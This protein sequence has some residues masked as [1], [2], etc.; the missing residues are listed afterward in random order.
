M[1][2][3]LYDL[4]SPSY[5]EKIL[6]LERIIGYKVEDYIR[7]AR[8]SGVFTSFVI[9]CQE[10]EFLSLRSH[11]CRAL[12]Y[13]LTSRTMTSFKFSLNPVE[14]VLHFTLSQNSLFMSIRRSIWSLS[15]CGTRTPSFYCMVLLELHFICT[16]A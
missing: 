6:I 11:S 7:S 4:I 2:N 14:G 10:Q 16:R 9:L 1:N 15:Y 12:G 5:K 8:E 13:L 3:E